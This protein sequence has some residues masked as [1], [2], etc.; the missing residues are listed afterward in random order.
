MTV[1]KERKIALFAYC[2]DRSAPP[3]LDPYLSNFAENL[4]R[5]GFEIHVYFANDYTAIGGIDG[6][7]TSID[8]SA[9]S[10]HINANKYDM[11]LSIN[12]AL[13]T[14]KLIQF[15]DFKI[16]SLIVDDFNHLFNHDGKGK[17]D[18]FELAD[19]VLFS[20]YA[21]ID[22]L[23]T[24]KPN[25]KDNVKFYP[26]ATKIKGTNDRSA[27][28]N[29]EFLH[30]ISWVASYLDAEPWSLLFRSCM[31]DESNRLHLCHALNAVKNNTEID[32]TSTIDGTSIND[33]LDAHNWTKNF[34]V[35]Q[36]QNSISNEMRLSAVEKLCKHGLVVYGNDGWSKAICGNSSIAESIKS[37]GFVKSHDDLMKIYNSSRICINVP[38]IQS[39][40]ALPYRVMDILASNALLI[41]AYHENSDMYEIFGKDCPIVT[42]RTM[43]ELEKLCSYYLENEEE[44]L[45]LVSKGNK[46]VETGFD[47]LDRSKDFL[48]L[49]GI[50]FDE[51]ISQKEEI[52]YISHSQFLFTLAKM[53]F[54]KL[55]KSTVKRVLMVFF[56]RLSVN[57]KMALIRLLNRST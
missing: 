53:E 47:F 10:K 14:E 40:G 24:H 36:I 18:S 43:E 39:S 9:L 17:Y 33:I 5:L 13:L 44:R 20:S 3:R 38:Q 50:V 4:S 25:L 16:I 11:A 26:T 34:F 21:H 12:N 54:N 2:W 41:T 7:N 37:A 35:M 29:S 22:K 28:E 46:L 6:L 49:A 45:A 23:V 31:Q 19:Y 52:K 8:F 15:V 55:F 1:V 42:Y 48:K 27:N 32:Y 51:N 56:S 57:Q 30:E